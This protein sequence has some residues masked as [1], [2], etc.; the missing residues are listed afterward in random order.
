MESISLFYWDDITGGSSVR[1]SLLH[2]T[3]ARKFLE[4]DGE[5]YAF[6]IYAP[7]CGTRNDL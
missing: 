1:Q 2:S 3:G 5:Q 7:G 6:E 4:N